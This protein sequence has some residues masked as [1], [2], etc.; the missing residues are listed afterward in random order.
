LM[1]L[2]ASRID[3]SLC[4]APIGSPSHFPA[5]RAGPA[6]GPATA[7]ASDM[8][9]PMAPAAPESCPLLGL[10]DDRETH[11]AFPQ[12]EHRCFAKR[13]PGTIELEFQAEYCLT[14]AY[15]TCPRYRSAHPTSTSMPVSTTP[16][17]TTSTVA[18]APATVMPATTD[19]PP[20]VAMSSPPAGTTNAPTP[21]APALARVVRVHRV[22]SI[23]VAALIL[24]ALVVAVA[25][26]TSL[27]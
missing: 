12:P 16:A 2:L 24:I 25:G 27:R 15:P 26:I 19:A 6:A 8:I 17:T 22:R 4:L 1:Q 3:R 20:A 13:N 7:T 11:F 9:P 14:A 18:P 10:L 5:H 23:L 21:T